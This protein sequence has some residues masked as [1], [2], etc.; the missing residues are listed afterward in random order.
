MNMVEK[1]IVIKHILPSMVNRKILKDKSFKVNIPNNWATYFHVE[2]GQNVR[3]ILSDSGF[4]VEFC[5]ESINKSEKKE[6]K[7]S[8]GVASTLNLAS[9]KNGGC[10]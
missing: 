9:Q 4:F 6:V 7:T 1:S 5:P 8:A 3:L 10:S 2:K